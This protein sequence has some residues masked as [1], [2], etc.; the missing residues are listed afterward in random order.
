[1]IY[2][3]DFYGPNLELS[4]ELNLKTHLIYK[5][6]S[7]IVTKKWEQLV[8]RYSNFTTLLKK[9]KITKVNYKDK[10]YSERNT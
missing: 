3:R 2:D 1:M 6:K 4:I 5:D 8:K 7:Y 10:I 9:L